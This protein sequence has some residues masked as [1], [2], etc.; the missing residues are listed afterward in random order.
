[1]STSILL[2]PPKLHSRF[3]LHR[4]HSKRFSLEAFMCQTINNEIVPR[5]MECRNRKKQTITMCGGGGIGTQ[6]V[7]RL[8]QLISWMTPQRDGYGPTGKSPA[9]YR[10]VREW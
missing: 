4:S 10:N 6:L 1:M 3:P 7:V 9:V 8:S 5:E 2:P